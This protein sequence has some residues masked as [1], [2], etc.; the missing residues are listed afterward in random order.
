M[1]QTND[2]TKTLKKKTGF[3]KSNKFLILLK[4]LPKNNINHGLL[5]Q[6]V[7]HTVKNVSNIV[8]VRAPSRS[9]YPDS[10]SLR[11]IIALGC[12]FNS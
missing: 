10:S 6:Y 5:A 7:P 9:K 3:I 4:Y 2:K 11:D 12:V 1:P 8:S